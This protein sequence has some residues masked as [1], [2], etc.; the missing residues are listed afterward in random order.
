MKAAAE[1]A[2]SQTGPVA[3]R[4]ASQA[5]LEKMGP[6]LPE[7]VGGS[8]DLTP[9]NN[10]TWSG[11][12]TVSD[13]LASGNY[14]HFGVREFGMSAICNG[15]A[16][17]Q[18][19]IPYAGTFLVFSDYARSAV[20]MAGLMKASTILVYTHDSVGLG[21]DGPTH[22]PIEQASGLRMIPNMSLWR[23][24]DRLETVAAWKSAVERRDGPTALL[25]TRQKID[26]VDRSKAPGGSDAA[27]R[28]GY[29]LRDCEGEPEAILMATGSEVPIAMEA[30]ERLSGEGKKVRVVSM[31]STDVF[32]AQPREYRD[33]VLPP[34]VRRRVAVEAGATAFWYKYVGLDGRVVGLDRYGESAPY[35][36]LFDELGLTAENVAS[37]LRELF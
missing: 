16:L 20:R 33:E 26:P 5:V 7:L 18:G 4:K 24:C 29:V 27:A 31:P 10:T 3:T 6:I 32:D 21:E 28:G 35:E 13:D 9:S 22:Q 12:V 30:A 25:F 19:V 34:C 23:P 2:E 36:E 15:M 17:Y 11:S 37:Q 8:A 14:V 1:E